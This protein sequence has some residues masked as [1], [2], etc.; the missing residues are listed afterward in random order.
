MNSQ[1]HGMSD[2]SRGERFDESARFRTQVKPNGEITE[3]GF[4]IGL[5]SSSSSPKWAPSGDVVYSID[6]QRGIDIIRWKGEHYVPG[7]GEKGRVPGTNGQAAA[8]TAQARLQRPDQ[9]GLVTQLRA[10]GW[11]PGFCQLIA[12]REN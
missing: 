6:Y 4:F 12:R 8:T 2:P 5:G 3:Q 1:V 7:K 11:S 10:Q 9:D